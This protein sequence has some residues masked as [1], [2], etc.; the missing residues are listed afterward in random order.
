MKYLP[1][2]LDRAGAVV[3]EPVLDELTAE[4]MKS[5]DV[6]ESSRETYRK[7]LKKFLEWLRAREITNPTRETILDYKESLKVSGL[8]SFSISSYIVTVRKFFNWLEATRGLPNIAKGIKGATR[9]RG[10]SGLIVVEGYLD[11]LSIR[12]RAG[13]EN[14][15]ALGD[16]S[17]SE[18]KLDQALKYGARAFI[19]A[20]DNDKAGED[21]MQ[22]ALELLQKRDLRAY[23]LILPDGIKDPDE[24]IKTRGADVF[25]T[26]CEAAQSGAQWKAGRILRRYNGTD[27]ARDQAIDEAIVYEDG[28]KDPIESKDF[29]DTV[30][31]G[32]R[33]TPSLLEH[34]LLTYKEKRAQDELRRGYAELF[35]KGPELLRA[36]DMEKAQDEGERSYEDEI[37]LKVTVLKNRNGPVNEERTL[38]FNRPLL[39]IKDKVNFW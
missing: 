38:V 14:V 27:Q 11:A 20:L 9:A 31:R 8:S 32:L 35:T 10:H 15:I 34:R 36:G 5:Q 1:T 22:R 37:E 33:L 2:K 29:L 26:L 17:F 7:G 21:G 30:T 39:T 19:L 16:A 13:L 23:V 12:E 28:L 25:R 24:L 4:F 3:R 6:R 18:T